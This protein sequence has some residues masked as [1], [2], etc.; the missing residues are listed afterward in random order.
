MSTGAHPVPHRVHLLRRWV[1]W[2]VVGLVAAAG[3]SASPSASTERSSRA[4]RGSRGR[5][6]RAW[7]RGSTPAAAPSSSPRTARSRTA[8]RS[9]STW[10]S[11]LRSRSRPERTRSRISPADRES[12]ATEEAADLEPAVGAAEPVPR[13]PARRPAR[14][15]AIEPARRRRDP[16]RD[17]DGDG[18]PGRGA[19]SAR[20]PAARRDRQ[21]LRRHRGAGLPEAPSRPRCARSSSRAQ[22]RSTSPSSAPTPSTPS[23]P[24]TSSR[25]LRLGPRL[26]EGVPRLGAPV[27][28][29]REGV[30]RPPRARHDRRRVRLRRARDAARPGRRRSRSRWSSAAPQRATTR[31]STSRAREISPST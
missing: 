10:S 16:V 19:G 20:L 5:R 23:A 18:R 13:H 14:H 7:W 25:A 30:E 1:V 4:R 31:P 9:G 29:A 28:R 17:A 22:P 8:A 15:R 11:C 6:S 3:A 26:P 12:A 21:L 2:L 27:R 24:S